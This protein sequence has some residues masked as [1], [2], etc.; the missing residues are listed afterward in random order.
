MFKHLPVKYKAILLTLLG[1]FGFTVSDAAV[2]VLTPHYSIY[3]IIA[4]DLFFASLILLAL[5]P[6]FGGLRVLCDRQNMKLHIFRGLMNFFGS[7]LVV[8]ALSIMP[9]AAFYTIAF[10]QPFM[11]A[12]VAIPLYKEH[13]GWHR[14]AAIAVGFSAIIIAFRPWENTLDL[15]MMLLLLVMPLV[16]AFL[17][18]V[19]RSMKEPKDIAVG[20]YPLFIACVLTTPLMLMGEGFQPFLLK[21]MPFLLTSSVC[22]VI[23]FLS[24]SRAFHMAEASLIAPLQYSQMIWG[25]AL[26]LLLF[27]DFPDGWM[28]A[29]SV[30]I[31]SSG[32]YLIHREHVMHQKLG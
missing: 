24:I 27:G 19:M 3:Q 16:F 25:L 31:I 18:L 10:L 4:S 15:P 11:M 30:I 21:H 22:I 12:I 7:L 1:Y 20:F 23:G 5:A 17:H 26:G 9:L 32:I 28:L 14:W 2:K 13:V 8:Y 6:K 29:G